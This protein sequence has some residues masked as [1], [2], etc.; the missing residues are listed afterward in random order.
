MTK[1][2]KN[3]FDQIAD[4][5]H[6]AYV[7]HGCESWGRHEFYGILKEEVDELWDDIKADAPQP[8]VLKEA[9]QVAAMV[10]RYLETGDRVHSVPVFTAK[11]PGETPRDGCDPT[12]QMEYPNVSAHW[13]AAENELVAAR[14][15]AAKRIA[16]L[17]AT[18]VDGKHIADA[19]IDRAKN[20]CRD[21]HMRSWDLAGRLA[22][23]AWYRIPAKIRDADPDAAD[24]E[25]DMHQVIGTILRTL[26]VTKTD[27]A[28]AG[29]D[30]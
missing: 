6:D 21:C 23:A 1:T 20:K 8:E 2:R 7:K 18:L 16:E 15:S 10:V 14:A 9:I 11:Q 30:T 13:L 3:I 26:V 24:W 29:E 17:E 22:K 25:S 27:A 12:P 19:L 28:Q 5:L 4:E